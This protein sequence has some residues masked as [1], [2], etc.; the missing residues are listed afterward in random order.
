MIWGQRL[1]HGVF[2]SQNPSNY[3]NYHHHHLLSLSCCKFLGSRTYVICLLFV[4]CCYAAAPPTV[5]NRLDFPFKVRVERRCRYWQCHLRPHFT[6]LS[7]VSLHSVWRLY[8]IQNIAFRTAFY[9]GPGTEYS[10]VGGVIEQGYTGLSRKVLYLLQ[11]QHGI[12]IWRVRAFPFLSS[13]PMFAPCF[14]CRSA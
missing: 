14:A 4:C 6:C 7:F 2:L 1:H 13:L 11:S 12:S 9:S 10:Y 5:T 3:C 8:K